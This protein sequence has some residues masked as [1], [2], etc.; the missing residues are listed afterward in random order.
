VLLRLKEEYDGAEPAASSVALLNLLA[1][2]HLTGD[3][4]STPKAPT[5]NSQALGVAELGVGNSFSEKIDTTLGMFAGSASMRG[6][7]VP[8]ML[9][10]LSTYH[11][12][13]P[14]IVIVGAPGAD[15]TR[16]LAD[17]VRRHYIPTAVLVAVREARRQE[18]SRLLPWTKDLRQRDERATAYVC[19]DFACQ[20]PTTLAD[21]LDAQL[22][23]ISHT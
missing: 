6:R 4:G 19:R 13:M 20:R 12:G 11:S 15:D 8:M 10:A 1:L 9:A 3:A 14:Q 17:V 21:E 16:A 2:S 5:P 23:E 22:E 18:L 7:A